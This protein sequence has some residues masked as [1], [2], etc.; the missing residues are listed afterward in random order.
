MG[1]RGNPWRPHFVSGQFGLKECFYAHVRASINGSA[2]GSCQRMGLDAVEIVLRTEELFVIEISDDEAASVRTVGDFYELICGKLSIPPLQ[3]PSTSEN[4]PVITHRE[5][6]FLFLSRH[7][8]LPAPSNVS[9]W[10]PQSVWD[11]M[12][13]V[14]V[15]QM[16][17]KPQEVMHYARIAQDLGVD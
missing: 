14:F 5:K 7:T 10:T 3:S 11:C 4:L 13:A 8:P 6:I 12:V 16:A 17:L 1:C 15:D 9:P 2:M